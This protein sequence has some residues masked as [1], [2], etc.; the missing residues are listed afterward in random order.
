MKLAIVRKAYNPFGGAERYLDLLARAL[1]QRGH[2]VHVFA[3][4]WPHDA[5][6]PVAFHRVP[7]VGGLSVLKV[8]SFAIAAW[9]SLRRFDGEVFSN[10]RLF[11]QDVFRAPDGVHRTWL[12]TRRRHASLLKRASMLVNPLHWSVRFLDWYIFN[13]RAFRTIIVA[14]EFVKQDILRAYRRVRASDVNVVYNGVDLARFRAR[15]RDQYEATRK[16]LNLNAS[17]WVLA[18]IGT[19]FERKGLRYAIGAL[20]HLPPDTVLLVVGRGSSRRYRAWARALGVEDRVRFEGPQVRV[21]RYYAV[22]DLLVLPALYE[23]MG[24]VILEALASGVPVL[25]SRASGGAEIVSEGEDGYVIEEPADAREVAAHITK[26]MT[27]ARDPETARRAR[28]KA[29]RFSLD[30]AVAETLAVL[31]CARDRHCGSR[32]P[33]PEFIPMTKAHG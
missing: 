25:T 8:W 31:S 14:S 24:N 15:T 32:T 4:R 10:E 17:Q 11:A 20:A 30:R 26:A 18:F 7:M 27:W 19:G 5:S 21:E 16:E 23:P 1:A 28:V 9:V 12:R 33:D 29:E 2:E 3:H 6:T 22:A 13:R